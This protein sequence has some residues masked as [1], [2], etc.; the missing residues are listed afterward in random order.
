MHLNMFSQTA[1]RV[2]KLTDKAKAAIE[3]KLTDS[4]KKRKTDADQVGMAP[5]QS[6][7][8]KPTRSNGPAKDIQSENTVPPSPAILKPPLQ[9][10]HTVVQIEEAQARQNVTMV[11]DTSEDEDNIP[12]RESSPDVETPEDELSKMNH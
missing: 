11:E 5:S 8:V 6:K 9:A 10:H 3:E 2:S 12:E 7:R 1:R 4:S